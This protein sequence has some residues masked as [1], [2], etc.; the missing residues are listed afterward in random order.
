MPRTENAP[1][2][3][4]EVLPGRPRTEIAL[5]LYEM[6]C[7][8]QGRPAASSDPPDVGVKSAVNTPTFSLWRVQRPVQKG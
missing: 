6:L 3:V 1:F 8:A 5:V 4:R 7:G 2:S